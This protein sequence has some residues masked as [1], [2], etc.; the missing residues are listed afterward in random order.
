MPSKI[1]AENQKTNATT[2]KKISRSYADIYYSKFRI[3]GV[4]LAEP[5]MFLHT[6]RLDII[7]NYIIGDCKI[8]HILLLQ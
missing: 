6:N 3:L 8:V 5:L 1:S 7:N 2:K 4:M